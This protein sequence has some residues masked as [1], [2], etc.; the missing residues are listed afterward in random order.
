[1]RARG[2]SKIVQQYREEL[3]SKRNQLKMQRTNP[4]GK[5]AS[6]HNADIREL[7]VELEAARIQLAQ[8]IL[9]DEITEH[10][11][12]ESL[13][14]VSRGFP[15]VPDVSS[16]TNLTSLD[17]SFNTVREIQPYVFSSLS[18]LVS[19]KAV[20]N[21]LIELPDTIAAC[22]HLQVLDLRWNFLSEL[23]P[24][25]FECT[26]L[27]TLALSYN[28]I[29]EI[30][31]QISSLKALATLKLDVNPISTIPSL[32]GLDSLEVLA[33]SKLGTYQ[34]KKAGTKR[35]RSKRR[36]FGSLP[37]DIEHCTALKELYA[38]NNQIKE[39]PSAVCEKLTR[40]E[41]LHLNGNRI[42]RLPQSF[43]ALVNLYQ[44]DLSRNR[45]TRDAFQGLNLDLMPSFNP[46]G[47]APSESF[48]SI[49]GNVGIN[50]L[51]DLD[52]V[53]ELN[54]IQ[55]RDSDESDE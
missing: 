1:M 3:A 14:L 10:R 49:E 43:T 40:L 33:I 17:L 13:D 39:L 15:E 35:E 8:Q 47:G 9:Q 54:E 11:D 36:K 46:S 7:R 24:Q 18:R 23:P 26:K 16:L 52:N 45:L 31:S 41:K 48:F 38:V 51:D 21:E 44:C 22:R 50:T 4:S 27:A 2:E 34:E 37:S 32:K 25:L 30:P 42:D 28:Q 53:R 19:F 5:E 12:M 6:A 29:A 55:H 20:Q